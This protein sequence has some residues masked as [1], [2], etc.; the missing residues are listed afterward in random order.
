MKMNILLLLILFLTTLG[1]KKIDQ[2]N[3]SLKGVWILTS[4]Q[5]IKTK[6]ML[7]YPDSIPH[8]ETITFNDS[9]SILSYAGTCN[10]GWG[11]CSVKGNSLTFPNGISSSKLFCTYYVWDEYLYYNLITA[12]EY[13]I[14]SNQL[15]IKSSGTFNLLFEKKP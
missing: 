6:Q 5:N 13:T 11:I 12:F 2:D 15:E 1:C 14:N 7:N 4:I 9:T 3:T 8:K 10:Y